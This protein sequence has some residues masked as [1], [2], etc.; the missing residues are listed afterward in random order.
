MMRMTAMMMI[1]VTIGAPWHGLAMITRRGSNRAIVWQENF[2][3]GWN[4]WGFLT[5][6]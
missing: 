3:T 4:A 5:V 1:A 6:I 2:G